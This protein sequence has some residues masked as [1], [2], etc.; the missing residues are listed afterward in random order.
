MCIS[1]E[2]LL[3][4]MDRNIAEQLNKAYEAFRQA[5]M[6]RDSAVKELK[7]KTDSYEKQIR[8]QQEQI[9]SLTRAVTKLKSQLTPL[10]ASRESVL[11]SFP[12][13]HL[14]E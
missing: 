14:A 9:E 12:N 7:Q 5:C 2:I 10:N 6:D 3:G 11:F 1:D 4:S 13:L 8:E